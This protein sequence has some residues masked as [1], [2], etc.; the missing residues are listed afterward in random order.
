MLGIYAIGTGEVGD[1][2]GDFVRFCTKGVSSNLTKDQIKDDRKGV[3]ISA[4]R[5]LWG[6]V[7]LF[8]I[9]AS[10]KVET[11]ADL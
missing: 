1:R 10:L 7:M 2:G 11:T 3:S 5:G 9:P 8:A 6:P 4:S